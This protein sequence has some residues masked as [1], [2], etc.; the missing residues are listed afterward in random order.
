MTETSRARLHRFGDFLLEPKTILVVYLTAGSIA[1]GQ[2]LSG[3]WLDDYTQY[4]NYVI[5]KQSFFHLVEGKDLYAL[6]LAEHWDFFKYSPTFAFLMAP[7]AILPDAIGLLLW[8]TLNIVAVYVAFR[9][10]PGMGRKTRAFMLWFVV[11][12]LVISVQN[13]QSN[14]LIAGLIVLAFVYLERGAAARAAL[15]VAMTVY[16]KLFGLVAFVLFLMY[17]AKRRAAVYAFLWFV[18][19]GGL[20][21]LVVS[22][23]QLSFLYASW[24]DL[25]AAD[26]M[27]PGL[28][29]IGW[30]RS[31]GIDLHAG[32]VLF[33][34]ALLLVA[35]LFRRRFHHDFNFRVLALASVLISVVIFNHK[36]ESATYVIALSGIALWYFPQAR[37]TENVVL[38]T[39]ALVLT[40]L[41]PGDL[42]PSVVRESWVQPYKLKAVPSIL[43]WGKIV[44]E[45]L[46]ATGSTDAPAG[47]DLRRG[48]PPVRFRRT[49]PLAP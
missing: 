42:F 23:Q 24:A 38:I 32:F 27:S 16:V 1:T 43:I 2:K 14:G 39:L 49:T 44:W 3:T 8:N 25:L 7:F 28:S 37:R 47:S 22:P 12:E 19:L 10:F 4:N 15:L 18:L 40:S 45:M 20:P 34:G 11:L 13:A 5:F 30:L 21:L 26:T 29:V 17:P 35:P 46:A 36:A 9:S 31:F 48:L 41:A 33:V 6:Y